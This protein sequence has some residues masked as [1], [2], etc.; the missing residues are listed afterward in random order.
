M[1]L[2]RRANKLYGHIKY[3]GKR[4][5]KWD[6]KYRQMAMST[7]CSNHDLLELQGYIR[8]YSNLVENW[9]TEFDKTLKE[10]HKL[11]VHIQVKL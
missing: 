10:M 8:Y 11:G 6:Q 1:I 7:D 2:R 5:N 4:I 3:W 9:K